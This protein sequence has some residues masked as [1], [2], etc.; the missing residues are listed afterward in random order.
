MSKLQDLINWISNEKVPYTKLQDIAEIGTG[1]GN[2]VDSIVR[3]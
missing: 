2:R 1:T 3:R